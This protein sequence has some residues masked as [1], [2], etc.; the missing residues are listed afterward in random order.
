[1]LACT[2]DNLDDGYFG[3]GQLLWKSIRK[4]G[5]EK[6]SKEILEFLPNRKSLSAREEQLVTREL[7]EHP[8]CMN[9][10]LGGRGDDTA[11]RITASE[12]LTVEWA[13]PE[14]R[15]LRSAAI[16]KSHKERFKLRPE[17]RVESRDRAIKI[18][19]WSKAG[20][21]GIRKWRDENP[22]KFALKQSLGTKGK[23]WITNGTS[24]KMGTT[25]P[26]GWRRGRH[27]RS[28]K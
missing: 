10:R 19:A 7:V 8:Q 22:T 28:L 17:L 23:F 27:A 18:G 21:L 12:L 9:L 25:I 3:S 6:H 5:K 14:S 1:M 11:Q 26:E 16:S 13:I 15:A 4:H 24:S 20:Q 2:T